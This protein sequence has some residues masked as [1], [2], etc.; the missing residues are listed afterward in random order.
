MIFSSTSSYFF[1]V[2]GKPPRCN[3]R[4]RDR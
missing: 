1:F 2:I 4:K 3:S